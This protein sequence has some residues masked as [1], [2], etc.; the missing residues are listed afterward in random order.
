M[1]SSIIWKLQN[2]EAYIFEKYFDVTSFEA[3]TVE[4]GFLYQFEIEGDYN[5]EYFFQIN[6]PTLTKRLIGKTGYEAT[7]WYEVVDEDEMEFDRTTKSYRRKQFER[8]YEF[9]PLDLLR[10][11]SEHFDVTERTHT[12]PSEQ[13]TI[14]QIDSEADIF[15]K[16]FPIT[17]YKE[18]KE[19]LRKYNGTI[20]IFNVMNDNREFRL[21]II[22]PFLKEGWPE[23]TVIGF[24]S[25][26]EKGNKEEEFIPL[27][28]AS[29]LADFITKKPSNDNR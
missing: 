16:H 21:C 18:E 12:V 20:Y 24:N 17:T 11:L 2:P 1:K 6:R 23:K 28:F 10:E 5:R 7:F 4:N 13:K 27:H 22:P 26:D 29:D 19:E 8:I 15:R 9:M 25:I 14:V 3:E